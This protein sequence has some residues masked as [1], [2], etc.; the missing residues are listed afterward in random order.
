VST[1]RASDY[2][3]RNPLFV[4]AAV[5]LFSSAGLCATVLKV[6]EQA[7]GVY[8]VLD[9]GVLKLEV[10]DDH[11]IR[12]LGLP[13][14]ASVNR[15]SLIIQE[16]ERPPAKWILQESDRKITLT[17][18]KL[19]VHVKRA[20]AEIGFYDLKGRPILRER[21]RGGRL[22]TPAEVGGEQT[23][24]IRQ[25]WQSPPDECIYGLGHHQH[26]LLNQRGVDIDLWQENWEVVVPM[27]SSSRGYGVLWDN[28]SHSKFGFPVTANWISPQSL[29]SKNGDAGGLSATY[30]NGIDFKDAKVYRIDPNINFDFKT[31]GPQIDN[32]FT[33]DPNWQSNPLHPEID[34]AQF[35]VRWQGQLLSEH[36]GEYVFKTFCTHNCRLWIDGSL[37]IDAWNNPQRYL[38][39]S[40]VLQA[41]TKYAIR[42]EWSRDA[43]NPLHKRHHGMIQLRWAP[44]AQEAY[45]GIT[46]WSEVGD[47]IDYYFIYGPKLDRVISGYRDLT[48][49]APLFGKYA[50]GYW[51]SH[52]AI[53]SQAAYLQT[54]DEFRDRDIPLDILVQDL[55]YWVPH[56]W[57]SHQFD[58]RRYP[59]PAQMFDQAQEKNIHSMISVWG[60]FQQGSANWQDLHDKELLFRYNNASFWTDKGT[61]H[62]NPF[63][64]QGRES[65]WR[66]IEQALFSKGVDAWWLDAPE[67]E[68][69]TPADPFLYKVVMNNNLGTG[70]R[71]LN[72]FSL[73]HTRGVYEHQRQAAPDR[74]VLILTRSAFAGQQ[75]NATVVWTGDIDGTFDVLRDQVACGLNYSLSGLPYWTTDIGGF[76]V[77]QAHWPLLNKDPGYRE[78]YTRWF[79]FATFCPIMRAHGCGPRR[80]MWHMGEEAMQ[81]QI[82]FDRLRYRL[83]PYLYS[84]AG[85]VTHTNDTIM[86]AL[87]LDF[88]QDRKSH[89]IADQYMFGPAF[90]VSPVLEPKTQTRPVYLPAGAGWYDFW[91]GDYHEGAQNRSTPTPLNRMPLYVRAGSILPLGPHQQYATEKL[92]PIELRVY[93]GANGAF[94][95]YEDEGENYNYEKGLF[96]TID[97]AWDEK[98]QTLTIGARQGSFPGMSKKRRFNVVWVGQGHGL[99][100][101]PEA[102][103]DWAVE[104][105]GAR[106][107]VQR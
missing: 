7:D 3:M 10:I 31:F 92:D 107:E 30:Y 81:V 38:S 96:S 73:L 52:L 21:Q 27:F 12:V 72:S 59:D 100:I 106:V 13:T 62:Y 46:M 91:S 105:L 76:F 55:N 64:E 87:V 14:H 23:Y 94:T 60:M 99:G 68:I 36:A 6:E 104:Y 90:L 4:L 57:G 85:A 102:Q 15:K 19:K 1:D 18:A 42:C 103:A 17:T 83:M 37:V 48:G 49:R 11:I 8:F 67:P 95:L 63:H 88:P 71:Y 80:E 40:I 16:N 79:Q 66:Q 39:G 75:K 2:S 43:Q 28:Y 93:T 98:T 34:P 44:P 50:Y 47:A 22:I 56:P 82:A 41:N 54:I 69:S 24:H 101:E 53:Q 32:S 97:F 26:G 35:S 5:L 74:R 33:T 58:T 51:H 84:V 78:L 20:S 65:Y 25:Q 77:K 89:G 29:F 70:A 61:W 86:R 45:D 9:Q